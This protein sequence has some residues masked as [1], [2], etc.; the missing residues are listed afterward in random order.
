MGELTVTN[1]NVTA[2][3][4]KGSISSFKSLTLN[5]CAI[6]QPTDA[7]FSEE[8]HGV[9]Y[10]G[11]LAKTKVVI[12]PTKFI[13]DLKIAGTQITYFNCS[14]LSVIPGVTGTVRYDPTTKTLTLQNAKIEGPWPEIVGIDSDIENLKIN[15]IGTCSVAVKAQA[16][17]YLQKS[18]TITG[19]GTLNVTSK[20]HTGIYPLSK[21]TID[22]CTVKVVSKWGICGDDLCKGELTVTNANVTVKGDDSAIT[23]LKSLTFNDCAITQ[24]AGAAFLRR[25]HCVALN[26]IVVPSVVIQPVTMTTYDLKIAG[27][28]VTSVNCDDLSVIP[29]VTGIVRYDHATKTL[30]MNYAKITGSPNSG[31]IS[32]NIDNLK[33]N[34]SG[35]CSVA[36]IGH[37]ALE[38][39]RPSSITGSGTLN[40]TSTTHS[41]SYFNKT[42]LTIDGCTVKAV[43]RY[44]ITGYDGS[45]EELTIRNADVTAE[46]TAFGSL[47]DIKTLTL[48]GCAITQPE[49][50]AFSEELHGVALGGAL[51][52]NKVVISK[53]EP[54]YDVVLE[55]HNSYKINCV[56]VVRS[57][58]GL[59][60]KEALDLVE[61]APCLILENLSLTEAAAARDKF[62]AAGGTANIYLHGTWKSTGIASPTA[63]IPVKKRGVYTLQGVRLGDSLDRLPAG[64]YI[65]DGRKVVKK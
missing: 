24:P 20:D 63:D 52:K 54:R 12:M 39:D 59:G 44:G 19:S 9:A 57:L 29:G 41:G 37:A 53:G 64:I 26:E 58:T 17:L 27:T 10:P 16:A 62:I 35:T 31:G 22:G 18:S 43:G 14:D 8:F 45:V 5:G 33:I 30:T 4:S 15:V 7:A 51:V 28:Q 65:V 61:A 6:I 50:A 11:T 23:R 1:A 46:G 48:D 32:S 56:N 34:V 38:L 60:L 3:G 49:G 13:Y 47:C 25:F 21:L 55:W 40:A 42:K 2:Y 36:A